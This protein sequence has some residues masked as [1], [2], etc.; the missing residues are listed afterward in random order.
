MR[1]GRGFSELRWEEA[2]F[3]K[4][5]V[6]LTLFKHHGRMTQR[7]ASKRGT[8]RGGL[9]NRIIYW[10]EKEESRTRGE[11]EE[12]ELI[13]QKGNFEGKNKTKPKK[14]KKKFQTTKKKKKKR[15]DKKLPKKKKKKKTK[16]KPPPP[17]LSSTEKTP[18][19]IKE[20]CEEDSFF[21]YETGSP[22]SVTYSRTAALRR[23]Y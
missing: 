21:F 7:Y 2:D 8:R 17:P 10:E 23:K 14:N 4:G 19:L 9:G 22:P 11:G 5:D 3:S 16:K 15:E 6:G 1:K 20:A 12:M 13:K 18:L